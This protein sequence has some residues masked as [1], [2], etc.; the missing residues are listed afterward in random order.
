MAMKNPER[1]IGQKFKI[2]GILETLITHE[3]K[4]RM[5]AIKEVIVIFD[6]W[7]TGE[8]YVNTPTRI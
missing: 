6:E 8:N 7:K 4:Y 3:Q 1:Y 2:T 5:I